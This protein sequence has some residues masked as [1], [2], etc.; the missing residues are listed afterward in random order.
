MSGAYKEKEHST[1]VFAIVISKSKVRCCALL[2]LG[3]CFFVRCGSLF[4]TYTFMHALSCLFPAKTMKVFAA[5]AADFR[6]RYRQL[7]TPRS[8]L[9]VCAS[10]TSSVYSEMTSVLNHLEYLQHVYLHNY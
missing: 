10:Y 6:F 3:R 9:V 8:S 1:A 7:N 2:L 5:Q 4:P